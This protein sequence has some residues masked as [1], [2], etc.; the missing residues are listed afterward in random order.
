MLEPVRDES[1][2][3]GCRSVARSQPCFK[4]CKGTR[5]VK[6]R[7][8]DD[9]ADGSEVRSAKPQSIDPR[10]RAEVTHDH[11][12]K[13]ADHEEDERKVQDKHRIRK[14]LKWQD[15]GHLVEPSVIWK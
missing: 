13:P 4:R 3:V 6:P 15:G 1:F 10:P 5:H 11:E 8:S 7:L 2:R 12:D 9:E 14:Q